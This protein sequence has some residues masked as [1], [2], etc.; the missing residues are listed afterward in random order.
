MKINPTLRVAIIMALVAGILRLL[1]FFSGYSS[2]ELARYVIFMHMFCI[3]L[4]VFFGIRASQT[5]KKQTTPGG[6]LKSA[7]KAGGV[8]TLIS[9]A[10]VF[11]YFKFIDINYF[12]IKQ[13]E[14]IEA[15]VKNGGNIDQIREKVENFFSLMN[16]TTVTLLGLMMISFM[17]SVL[18][19]LIDR[20]VLNRFT[21]RY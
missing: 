7:I 17:Y 12:V 14:L 16:Y 10:F 13:Q 3:L 2:P 11:I 8:Y 15:E 18:V 21:N 19:V 1:V 4:S 9:T 20:Y 6:D 5:G